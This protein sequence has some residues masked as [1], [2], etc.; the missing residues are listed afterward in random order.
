GDSSCGGGW[1]WVDHGTHLGAH[2]AG[3]QQVTG[4][5]AEGMA[6]DFL[7]LD[8][9]VPEMQPSWDLTW[10]LVRLADR[11]QVE[12]VFVQGALR[13]WQGW[14]TDWDARALL[15]QVREIARED[16]GRAPIQRVHPTA[17]EHRRRSAK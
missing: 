16:I 13:L 14:T 6:A 12:A 5:I 7:L 2:A 9:D 1:M 10:E 15:A 3:L 11:S 17:D 4:A 8:L